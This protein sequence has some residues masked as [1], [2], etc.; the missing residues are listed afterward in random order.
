MKCSGGNFLTSNYG[1][2]SRCNLCQKIF[3]A[4][5]NCRCGSHP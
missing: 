1:Y 3:C 4:V 2:A 5:H